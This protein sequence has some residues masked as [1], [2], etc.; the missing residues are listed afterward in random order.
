MESTSSELLA[1]GIQHHKEGRLQEALNAFQA[2]L[3]QNSFDV[4]ALTRIALILSGSG[5]PAIIAAG[6]ELLRR[7]CVIEP[8]YG[9][10][11]N[12]ANAL[13]GHFCYHESLYYFDRAL[14]LNPHF[15]PSLYGKSSI[16]EGMREGQQALDCLMLALKLKPNDCWAYNDIGYFHFRQGNFQESVDYF[17]KAYEISP[18][19]DIQAN[20]ALALHYNAQTNMGIA[21]MR[22]CLAKKP[23]NPGYHQNM[24]SMLFMAGAFKEAH[25]HY[26]WRWKTGPLAGAAR[27]FP[28]P[29]WNGENLN[30]KTILIYGEQGFGDSLQYCRFIPMMAA[31]GARVILDVPES[32]VRL[33]T[34]LKG[35]HQ[36]VATGQELPPFDYNLPIMDLPHVFG[37]SVETIPAEVPYLFADAKDYDVWKNRLAHAGRNKKIGLAWAGNP[38]LKH[39]YDLSPRD[40]RRSVDIEAFAPILAIPGLSFYSLQKLYGQVPAGVP[41]TDFMPQC[42]DF[43]DTAALMNQLDLVV[44]V[45]SSVVHLA[46]AL[47][48][49]VLLLNRFDSCWRWLRWRED[50]P[51][52]PTLR[53]LRQK[54]PND[55]GE[56]LQRLEK[57][58]TEFARQPVGV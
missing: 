13:R 39:P 58:L 51:W 44:T 9:S 34:T 29:E 30:G 11:H 36:V 35:V 19:V 31:L 24:S 50:S 7:V 55:W 25:Q 32:L 12:L 40:S 53:M 37:T 8:N 48:K 3:E 16:L 42:D 6:M 21:M 20:L 18:T 1:L 2:V 41:I 22:E 57:E 52:Y 45:D 4:D 47:G 17:A 46:G 23:E 43:A 14:E 28:V 38:R 27:H 54:T 15:V 56:V 5:V 10:F 33:M 26:K 49:P